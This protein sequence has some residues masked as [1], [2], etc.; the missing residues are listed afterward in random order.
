MFSVQSEKSIYLLTISPIT[1]SIFGF[2][3]KDSRCYLHTCH[4]RLQC[5]IRS[6]PPH[7]HHTPLCHWQR[8]GEGMYTYMALSWAWVSLLLLFPCST[9]AIRCRLASLLS[10]GCFLATCCFCL[11]VCLDLAFVSRSKLLFFSLPWKAAPWLVQCFKLNSQ[12]GK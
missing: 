6:L 10:S 7:H 8:R 3:R 1:V 9:L 11:F 12:R 2:P 5:S 4:L